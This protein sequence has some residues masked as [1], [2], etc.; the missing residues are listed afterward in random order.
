MK[1]NGDDQME[2]V[3]L[4]FP[5]DRKVL[6]V[7]E[8]AAKLDCS[9]EHVYNL[10]EEGQLRAVNIS[11]MNNLTDRRC[12]RIPIEAWDAFIKARSV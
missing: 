8:C 7:E 6:R 5:K 1:P 9:N 2:F 3:S 4:A 12:L 10:I 11:G